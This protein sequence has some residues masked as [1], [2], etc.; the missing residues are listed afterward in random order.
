VPHR[1]R[2][3]SRRPAQLFLEAG[4]AQH[5]SALCGLERNRGRCIALGTCR[6]RFRTHTRSPSAAL[7]LALLAALRI[8]HELF[9]VEEKLLTCGEH[10]LCA[11]VDAR[12][13]SIG[14]FH[15]RLPQRR[16]TYRYR[17]RYSIFAGPFPCL[18]SCCL[19]IE[20]PGREKEQRQCFCSQ[21]TI[22]ARPCC[23]TPRAEASV[24]KEIRSRTATVDSFFESSSALP[25]HLARGALN[26]YRRNSFG[27]ITCS[28]LVL[29]F[30]SLFAITLA[31]QSCL[32]TTLFARF[33]V[34]GVTLDFLDDVFLLNLPLES[35]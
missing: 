28:V 2:L 19:N 12:Q 14:K 18:R 32:D 6:A 20:G 31:C 1:R 3:W 25:A 17:P 35:A 13:N 5:R 24:G 21:A 9:V 7:R 30:T 4:P 27:Y 11:A 16:E 10:K 22:E 29:L 26:T 33:Q 15:G 8:V 34:V 23:T